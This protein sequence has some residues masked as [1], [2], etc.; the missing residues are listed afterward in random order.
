MFS[1]SWYINCEQEAYLTFPF[2]QVLYPIP[3]LIRSLFNTTV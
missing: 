2:L 3:R 1:F